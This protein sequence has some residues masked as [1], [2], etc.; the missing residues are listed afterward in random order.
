MTLLTVGLP[1]YNAMPYLPEAV[2][3]ILRQDYSHF[4]L[5]IIN[6]GSSDASPAYLESLTD[7]RI[8]LYHQPNQGLGYTLNRIL[9]LCATRYLARMDADDTMPPHRLGKQVTFLEGH[10]A[11]GLLGT[12]I[13]FRVGRKFFRGAGVPEHH[14]GILK[15]F[16][17]GAPGVS[18]ASCV[19]RTQTAKRIGGYRLRREGEDLDFCLRMCEVAAVANLSETL[20]HIRLSPGSLAITRRDEISRG[21]AYGL[22]CARNRRAHLAEPSFDEFCIKW[23]E[24]SII[25]RARDFLKGWGDYQYRKALFEEGTGHSARSWGRK[26]LA[27]LCNPKKGFRYLCR[28]VRYG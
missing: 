12:Q 21:Y 14:Q 16:L 10:P 24:R 19:M 5:L 13:M 25:D 8:R 2:D 27:G 22:T 11:V 20:Y 28:L 26:A 23:E 15:M 7:S 6:D 3:S 4:I 17:H 9:E 1:V 18:H